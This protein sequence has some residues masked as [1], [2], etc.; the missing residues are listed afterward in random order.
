MTRCLIHGVLLKHF[1]FIQQHCSLQGQAGQPGAPGAP[2]IP[3][4]PGTPGTP[5]V[6]GTP[7]TSGALETP[8][9]SPGSSRRWKQCSWSSDGSRDNRDSGQ[10]H[11]RIRL[12]SQKKKQ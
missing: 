11:V 6:P 4:T 5:G 9:G 12:D 2:G 7:G 3:G 1:L 8:G 10:V